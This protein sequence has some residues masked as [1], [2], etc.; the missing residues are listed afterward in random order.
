M[1]SDCSNN[2]VRSVRTTAHDARRA[3]SP[4]QPPASRT[5]RGCRE[6]RGHG[7]QLT[8]TTKADVRLNVQ[9]RPTRYIYLHPGWTA[10]RSASDRRSPR[11][12]RAPPERARRHQRA[13]DPGASMGARRGRGARPARCPTAPGSSGDMSGEGRVLDPSG[14]VVW[15]LRCAT[16][17]FFSD[18]SSLRD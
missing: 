6:G 9:R 13:S 15:R 10:R 5:Q 11:R 14:G 4:R 3:A 7:I 2:V 8:R 17:R 1:G 18:V 12:R 16:I